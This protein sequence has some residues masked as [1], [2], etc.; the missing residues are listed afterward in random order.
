MGIGSTTLDKIRRLV[1]KEGWR[2]SKAVR[3]GI[4]IGL[5]LALASLFPQGRSEQR[6]T[7]YSIGALWSNEDVVAPYS[8]PLLKDPNRYRREVAKALESFYPVFDL[9]SGARRTTL[10]SIGSALDQIIASL[11]SGSSPSEVRWPQDAQ[12]T[13]EEKAALADYLNGKR[14]TAAPDHG[15]RIAMKEELLSLSRGILPEVLDTLYYTGPFP[16]EILRTE[17]PV[18]L[19]VRASE[20]HVISSSRFLTRDAFQNRIVAAL[21]ETFKNPSELRVAVAK[22]LVAHAAPDITYEQAH[23]DD[24]RAAIIRRVP[25]TDGIIP[26]GQAIISRGDVI[27]PEAKTALESLAEARLKRGGTGAA[28]GRALGTIGHVAIIMMLFVL[29]VRFIRR[30]IYKDNAQLLLIGLILLF[31]AILAFFSVQ[32]HTQ[33]PL[34]YLILIP[35]TSMLLTVLFDSRTGF[36]GTVIVALLVAGIRG[37]DYNIALAGLAAG[38]FAAYTVRD[39]R[40]RKQLFTSIGYIFLGYLI[41]ITALAFEK[42][43]PFEE[44]GIELLFAAGNA[45]ISPVLT[46]GLVF[47]I[48]GIFD[49]LS[50]MRLA[51]YEN[52]NHPLLRLLQ[53]EAPGTYHHTMLVAQLA[54]NAALAIGANSLLAKVGTYF[55]DIGKLGQPANFIE[56]Q[57]T[58]E[59][60]VHDSIDA[61]DSAMRVRSH[62][63]AG[64]RLAREHHLPEKIVDFIPMHHGT[65]RISFFYQK[66]LAASGGSVDEALFRYPGPKPN[67]KET[68]IVMLADAAEA[69]ARTIGVRIEEPTV[70]LLEQELDKLIRDR[71]ADGQ[72]DECDLTMRDLG[73][74]RTVFARLLIGTLHSRIVYP[75]NRTPAFAAAE[76]S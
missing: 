40:S 5:T 31:P 64:I 68:A 25:K 51:D 23:T 70:E 75:T 1:H 62:V 27:T 50:D 55:H 33:F 12:L 10:D 7:G 8:Y 39:L 59:N 13:E 11:D 49:T 54:E 42:A 17:A 22:L 21:E 58:G 61:T 72:L 71:I 43:S 15:I 30:K 48:E 56:N 19:R 44:V 52:I 47:A 53:E 3:L 34:E 67:T 29:Y 46:Y 35:V 41:A 60:N 73:I 65:L 63:T 32:I 16:E 9:D 2:R 69:V 38:A 45:L 66:A 18:S 20:E 28:I 6:V 14:R 76:R 57:I 74:I 4:A 36:Y 24:A 37:N 26:E